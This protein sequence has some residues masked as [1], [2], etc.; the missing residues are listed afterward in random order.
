MLEE[1]INR[2]AKPFQAKLLLGFTIVIIT[3]H[4]VHLSD[5]WPKALLQV[6]QTVEIKGSC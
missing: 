4:A 1:K 5:S 6:L 2:N 3:V